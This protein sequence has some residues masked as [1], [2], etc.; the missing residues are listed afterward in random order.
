LKDC[1][2]VWLSSCFGTECVRQNKV[3]RW[4]RIEH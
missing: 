2:L 3:G 1:A 4:G